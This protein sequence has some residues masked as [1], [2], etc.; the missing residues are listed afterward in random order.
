M[1]SL[2]VGVTES[3]AMLAPLFD[4][5][6]LVFFMMLEEVALAE[7]VVAPVLVSAHLAHLR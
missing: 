3:E 1:A 6:H 7:E 5:A 4:V 2:Q